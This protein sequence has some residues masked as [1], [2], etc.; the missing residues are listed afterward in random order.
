M[1][2]TTLRWTVTK[3]AIT[4]LRAQLPGVL[5]QPGWPGQENLLPDSI[6]VASLDGPV[7]IP[8]FQGGRKQRDDNFDIPFEVRVVNQTTLD[9]T[10]TH[11]AA[12]VSKIEDIFANDPTIGNLDGVVAAQITDEKHS[13]GWTPDGV[14]GFAEITVSVHSRLL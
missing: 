3:T 9:A 7:N 8:V 5:V 11:L 12:L 6:W 10:M 14:I 13:A 1:A 4:L 2:S